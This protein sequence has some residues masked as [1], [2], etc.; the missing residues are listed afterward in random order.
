[1]TRRNSMAHLSK[2]QRQERLMEEFLRRIRE[3]SPGER[4]YMAG[5]GLFEAAEGPAGNQGRTAPRAAADPRGG[6]GGKGGRWMLVGKS[7]GAGAGN[8]SGC[9]NGPDLY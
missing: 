2:K 6:G 8:L 4:V 9:R 5:G 3:A 7:S 1:M